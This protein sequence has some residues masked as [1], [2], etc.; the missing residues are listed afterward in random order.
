MTICVGHIPVCSSLCHLPYELGEEFNG[1]QDLSE[2]RWEP[3]RPIFRANPLPGSSQCLAE[4][5]ESWSM[6]ESDYGGNSLRANDRSDR[7][8]GKSSRWDMYITHLWSFMYLWWKLFPNMAG[9]LTVQLQEVWILVIPA[10]AITH[11]KDCF[12][13]EGCVIGASRGDLPNWD[14]TIKFSAANATPKLDSSTWTV[15]GPQHGHSLCLTKWWNHQ[16]APILSCGWS[17]SWPNHIARG[18]IIIRVL[19]ALRWKMLKIIVMIIR[20]H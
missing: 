17:F 9:V 14:A 16:L 10:A 18:R 5:A 4:S 19:P 8:W 6:I 2:L 3:K 15:Y 11:M 7:W 20:L 12:H 13:P 1:I